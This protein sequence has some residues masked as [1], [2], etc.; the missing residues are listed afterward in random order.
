[1]S[2]EF[3]WLNQKQWIKKKKTNQLLQ[4][5]WKS[6]QII[7]WCLSNTGHPGARQGPRVLSSKS[8]SMSCLSCAAVGTQ[9]W[10]GTGLLS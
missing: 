8:T 4:G 5:T 7:S 9:K 3:Y 10:V 2:D 1:M 6:L